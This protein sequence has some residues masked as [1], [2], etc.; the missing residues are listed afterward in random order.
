M[1]TVMVETGGDPGHPPARAIYERAGFTLLPVVT[2]LPHRHPG[3]PDDSGR[4]AAQ[5]W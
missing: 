3:A 4:S 5:G 1:T 2:L